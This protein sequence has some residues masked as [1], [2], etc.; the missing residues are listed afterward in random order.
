MPNILM[1]LNMHPENVAKCCQLRS[2]NKLRVSIPE[3]LAEAAGRQVVPGRTGAARP[4]SSN[5]GTWAVDMD[6][7][8][9]DGEGC[10]FSACLPAY[11]FFIPSFA[12]Y[13]KF[14]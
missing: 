13:L 11:L 8:R 6:K 7:L 12:N 9:L 14:S 5:G 10:H 1:K 4:A 2:A 3:D